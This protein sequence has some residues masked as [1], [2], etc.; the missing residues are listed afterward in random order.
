MFHHTLVSSDELSFTTGALSNTYINQIIEKLNAFNHVKCTKNR[1]FKIMIFH[2]WH[3]LSSVF[4]SNS[5]FAYRFNSTKDSNRLIL[6][7]L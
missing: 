4:T 3:L 2:Q 1:S 5:F 7:F 6:Y